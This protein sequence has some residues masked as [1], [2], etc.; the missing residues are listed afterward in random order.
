MTAWVVFASAAALAGVAWY[1]SINEGLEAPMALAF[2]A[3]AVLSFPNFPGAGWGVFKGRNLCKNR[4]TYLVAIGVFA[5]FAVAFWQ[6]VLDDLDFDA[7]FA[8]GASITGLLLV[9]AYSDAK[10][11]QSPA[12]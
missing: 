3:I 12:E 6:G 10:K 9:R 5:L 7:P 8:F 4:P 11:L 2:T 1:L